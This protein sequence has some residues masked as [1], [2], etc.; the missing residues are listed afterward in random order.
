MT[1]VKFRF[2]KGVVCSIPIYAQIR[3]EKINKLWEERAWRYCV[4]ISIMPITNFHDYVVIECS[5]IVNNHIF[6]T[7][8]EDNEKGT[9]NILYLNYC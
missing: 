4:T 6:N 1:K 5:L 8:N 7:D 2:Y 9:Q 3:G